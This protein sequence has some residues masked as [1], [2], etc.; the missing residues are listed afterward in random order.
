MLVADFQRNVGPT[1]ARVRTWKDRSG[2]FK[3]DAEFVGM[4]GPNNEK[5]RLHKLNGVV[6][7]VPVLKM[8]AEDIRVLEHITKRRMRPDKEDDRD[9]RRDRGEEGDRDREASGTRERDRH[10]RHKAK[11]PSETMAGKRVAGAAGQGKKSETDWFDFFLNSG[12]DVDDCSRYASNFERDRIDESILPDLESGTLRSLGMREGDIIRVSKFI[13]NKYG[14]TAAGA[15][16]GGSANFPASTDGPQPPKKDS[17]RDREDQMADDEELARKL[18]EDLNA[19]RDGTGLFTTK[20]GGVKNTRRGRPQTNRSAPSAVSFDSIT[21][22]LT[23]D[24]SS[25]PDTGRVV[26]PDISKEESRRPSSTQPVSSGFEDDAWTVKPSS[27]PSSPALVDTS[28][29][30]PTSSKEASNAQALT[31]AYLESMGLSKNS[32]PS[33][34]PNHRQAAASPAPS[35]QSMYGQSGSSGQQSAQPTGYYAPSPVNSGPRAPPAPIPLNQQLL[36]PLIPTNTGMTGFVPTRSQGSPMPMM[37]QQ[38]GYQQPMQTGY[39][40]PQPTGYQPP[41]PSVYQQPQ[42][43]GFQSQQS[44][45]QQSQ[46]TAFQQPQ[47]TGFHQPVPQQMPMQQPYGGAQGY[48]QPQ[49]TGY[50]LGKAHFSASNLAY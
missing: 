45:F 8:S 19:G 34:A 49:P 33:S 39:Q 35:S 7:E 3:V 6:I 24:R 21:S 32:R 15:S 44:A 2:A 42:Q 16:G 37:N 31:D 12:C 30:M 27:K 10:D 22:S 38:T 23:G 17:R 50:P 41:H 29:S 9:R 46:P 36:N 40:Q 25:T 28:D 14:S 11:S 4:S 18:Q 1:L 47:P 13:K 5:I 48:Q 20:E 43:T 26:S